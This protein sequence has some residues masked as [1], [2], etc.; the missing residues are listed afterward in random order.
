MKRY[1][2]D[3]INEILG[4]K[5]ILISGPRQTGKT[6]LSK[7]I[8]DDFEYLNFDRLSDKKK[9]IK[10]EWNREAKLIIFDEIHK[11]KKWKQWLKGIYDT[12]TN[13]NI[14]VTGSARLDTHKKVGDSMAGRYFQYRLM[15]LCLKELSN[16]KYQNPVKNLNNLLILSGFPEPFL[17]QS[18]KFYKKWRRTHLDI[19]LR[20]DIL[21]T[22][23]VK[24][25]Q[26]LEFL[27]ELMKTRVG[28]TISY[29]SLKEDLSTD[30]KTIKRWLTI[31]ENS[32]VLFKI[33][34]YHK[35][36]LHSIKKS[37]KFFFYDYPRVENMGHRLENFVAL[38]LLKEIYF[39]NDTEGEDYS[40]HFLRDKDGNEID[41]IITRNKIPIK[42]IE[43][44][45]SDTH[46]SHEFKKLSGQLKNFHPKIECI[47]LVKELSRDFS[48]P[49]GYKVL[50][51]AN[52]LSKS[53]F[54]GNT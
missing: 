45:M 2:F 37:P 49:D 3:E 31:C 32:Y 30:D 8:S 12:E 1:L 35:N 41:F 5:I 43:V 33:T 11:M 39:Q 13:R 53:N 24:R 51:L 21:T 9:I 54:L 7:S 19:I 28:S 36:I 40:L 48:T 14:I 4:K 46:I 44:K 18:E 15:P 16:Q 25:I 6:T 17:N 47:Q 50:N 34:P 20:Q 38:S 22:E 29:N 23:S 10:T 52:F 27:I 42:A 26:D